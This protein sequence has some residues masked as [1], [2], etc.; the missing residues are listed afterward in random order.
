MAK[1]SIETEKLNKTANSIID[2]ANEYEILYK[3]LFKEVSGVSDYWKGTACQQ[4]IKVMEEYKEFYI[5][6]GENIEKYVEFIKNA[7]KTYHNT[8]SN[9][10]SRVHRLKGCVK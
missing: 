8:E 2:K 10:N 3:N 4:F 7:S 5:K 6:Y 9:I 1:I